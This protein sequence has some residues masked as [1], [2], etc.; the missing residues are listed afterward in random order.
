VVR[1]LTT[2]GELH[3]KAE[4]LP[5]PQ[6]FV[7]PSVAPWHKMCWAMKL[8]ETVSNI[9]AQE[10]FVKDRPERREWLDSICFVWDEHE[11]RWT[12]QVQ[13]AL[14]AYREVHGNLR[15]PESFAVPSVAPWPEVC[16][17]MKLGQ[18]VQVIRAEECFVKD[19]PERREWLDSIG[20]VWSEYEH[21]WTEQVQPALLA[22]REV[23]GDTRV[24]QSFV[25]PSE[26]P[27]PEACWEMKLGQTVKVIRAL[28]IFVKD[29]PE[30]REWLDSIGFVW[31]A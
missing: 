2:F 10:H 5:V 26:A 12:E 27:W 11:H 7:V 20:F 22:Y 29:R 19:R 28:E 30:R 6:S 24:P 16:W 8:G 25:V 18:T 14:L 15:V 23:H 17:R 31:R 4:W 3:S 21:R 1:A 13:P 9:R